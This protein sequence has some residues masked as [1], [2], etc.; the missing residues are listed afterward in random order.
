M[1]F[2]SGPKKSK[3]ASKFKLTS[4]TSGRTKPKKSKRAAWSKRYVPYL[5]HF[6][7]ATRYANIMMGIP[8]VIM[9]VILMRDIQR[10][11]WGL[12][13][14]LIPFHT[15]KA[16]LMTKV[17]LLLQTSVGWSFQGLMFLYFYMGFCC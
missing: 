1:C 17:V 15:D 10:R 16:T 2:S 3:L 5:Q 9:G 4:N 6:D 13:G 7:C 11:V 8:I 14:R 12:L